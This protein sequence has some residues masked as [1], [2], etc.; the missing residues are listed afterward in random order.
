M[1]VLSQAG[2]SE[3]ALQFCFLGCHKLAQ[4]CKPSSWHE[5]LRNKLDDWMNGRSEDLNAECETL[6]NE[7]HASS[8]PSNYSCAPAQNSLVGWHITL[9]Q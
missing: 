8:S 1:S 6:T 9:L 7:S 5:I 4:A 2:M 3:K